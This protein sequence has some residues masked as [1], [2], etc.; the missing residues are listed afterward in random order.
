M[1]KNILTLFIVA[2]F[3]ISLAEYRMAVP[4]EVSQGGSLPNGSI[5]FTGSITTPEEPE[6]PLPSPAVDDCQSPVVGI[7]VWRVNRTTGSGFVFWNGMSIGTLVSGTTSLSGNNGI[8]YT[9]NTSTPP[10]VQPGVDVYG[11]CR[12]IPEGFNNGGTWVSISPTVS[13]WVNKGA[14]YDCVWT[15]DSSN[16]LTSQSVVQ[17][18]SSCS[19]EQE[20]TT[21]ARE[22]NDSTF[23]IRNAGSPVISTQT[24]ESIEQPTRTVSGTE[25]ASEPET[26]VNVPYSSTLWNVDISNNNNVYTIVWHGG[27]ISSNENLGDI[28]TFDY[29]GVIYKRGEFLNDLT[30]GTYNENVYAKSY[31]VCRVNY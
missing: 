27:S 7:Y 13:S 28:T 20:K 30:S 29:N 26:C 21:Q 3:G 11:V 31:G 22:Q 1:K 9:K 2:T 15:P 10:I 4:M 6:T 5:S 12:N 23:M 25:T 17:R 14:P 16:Y 8:V 18:G 19:Q 24:I